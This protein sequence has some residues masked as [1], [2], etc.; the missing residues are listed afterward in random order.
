[1]ACPSWNSRTNSRA[2][3]TTTSSPGTPT[4]RATG[5]RA[6]PTA[7]AEPSTPT[8]PTTSASFRTER[9]KTTR[10]S[11]SSPMEPSTKVLLHISRQRP[12]EQTRRTRP[13]RPQERLPLRR[14]MARQQASRGGP[15]E[16][17]GRGH[18]IRWA[19]QNGPETL[20]RIKQEYQIQKD[21]PSD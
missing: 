7:R 8:A 12:E 20:F 6:S 9:P 17:P 5:C 21:K 1:M 3:T 4:T 16:N 15:V 18:R 19:F 11:S 2:S 13:A 14:R 10:A